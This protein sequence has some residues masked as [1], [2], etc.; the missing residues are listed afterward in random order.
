MTH[1]SF[2]R[3]GL[4]LVMTAAVA[5]A[6]MA[7]FFAVGGSGAGTR[8]VV[9]FAEQQSV[10]STC[11]DDGGDMVGSVPQGSGGQGFAVSRPVAQDDGGN[12]ERTCQS[13]STTRT[14]SACS[15]EQS[16]ANDNSEQDDCAGVES[17]TRSTSTTTTRTS[18]TCSGEQGDENDSNEQDDCQGV[19]G[20][21]ATTHTIAARSQHRSTRRHTGCTTRHGRSRGKKACKGSGSLNTNARSTHAAKHTHT[22]HA[23]ESRRHHHKKHRP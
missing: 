22:G 4:Q 12:N 2:G 21:T 19:E 6:M 5:L 8:G 14:G 18:S 17:T 16:D 1:G 11:G 9:A 15:E 23:S 7:A 3:R 20:S 13:T 10:A